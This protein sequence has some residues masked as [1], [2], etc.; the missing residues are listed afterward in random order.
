L[1]HFT[2]TNPEWKPPNEASVYI[3]NL[4]DRASKDTA[5]LPVLTEENPLLVSL[6]SISSL[7]NEVNVMN[8][9]ENENL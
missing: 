2:H 7:G 5:N 4:K 8:M 3:T 9:D 1:V 6:N